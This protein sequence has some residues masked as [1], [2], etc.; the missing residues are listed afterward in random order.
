MKTNDVVTFK[1]PKLGELVFEKDLDG[2]A[3]YDEDKIEEIFTKGIEHLHEKKIITDEEKNKLE[4][5]FALCEIETVDNLGYLMGFK[6][7]PNIL[8]GKVYPYIE[9]NS[10]NL[11]LGTERVVEALLDM[12]CQI[13]VSV[14]HTEETLKNQEE[15]TEEKGELW[16]KY[17]SALLSKEK[18]MQD[19]IYD[20]LYHKALVEIP[21]YATAKQKELLKKQ[22]KDDWIECSADEYA[23]NVIDNLDSMEEYYEG[24]YMTLQILFENI[25]YENEG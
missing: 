22:Y 5:I 10:Y 17:A 13:I 11:Y 15:N 8:A 20:K 19:L 21:K 7:K 16:A 23:Q 4:E 14:L 9:F 25:E 6:F 1:H 24:T 18:V 12:L 3:I 2:R